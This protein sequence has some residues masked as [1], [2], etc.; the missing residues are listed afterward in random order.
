MLRRHTK[1]ASAAAPIWENRRRASARLR[2]RSIQVD[3]GSGKTEV[4]RI[5]DMDKAE[6]PADQFG[7]FYSGD[8]YIVLYT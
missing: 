7:Q 3:D 6:V 4:W 1:P 2:A 8:S 5:E